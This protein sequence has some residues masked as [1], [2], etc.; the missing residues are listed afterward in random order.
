MHFQDV[1][2]AGKDFLGKL[3]TLD[4]RL[5]SPTI[6]VMEDAG[7]YRDI[8]RDQFPK[9]AGI[10]WFFLPNGTVFDIGKATSIRERIANQ[11]K[12]A[13]WL[14][15]KNANYRGTVGEGWGFPNSEHYEQMS[16]NSKEDILH[17]RFHVGWILIEPGYIS[18]MVEVYLQTLCLAAE[19][20]LPE[21]CLQIG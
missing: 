17:G 7:E 20:K 16:A 1:A 21:C 19:G 9:L 13:E 15:D 6:S 5:A 10:Y 14:G 11:A 8:F 12:T 4:R 18:A 2:T 3:S